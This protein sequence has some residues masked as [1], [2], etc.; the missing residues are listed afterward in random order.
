MSDMIAVSKSAVE[1]W[2][3]Q[4]EQRHIAAFAA[5]LNAGHGFQ[6]TSEPSTSREPGRINGYLA[7]PSHTP[8]AR[9]IA[10]RAE[11]RTSTANV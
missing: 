11:R 5:A 9:Y 8:F 2:N 6:I 7:V 1:R 10:E 4:A 3:E